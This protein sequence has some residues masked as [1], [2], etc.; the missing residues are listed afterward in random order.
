MI[1]LNRYIVYIFSPN[2]DLES[3]NQKTFLMKIF[4]G[5]ENVMT[6]TETL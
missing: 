1:K 3:V 5:L 6:H 4:Y 2:G